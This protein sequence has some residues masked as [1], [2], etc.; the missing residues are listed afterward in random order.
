LIG[1]PAKSKNKLGWKPKYDL[2]ALV[3]E[4]ILSDLHLRKRDEYL[5]D[6]GFATLNYFE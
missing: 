6:G 3:K 1:D 5:K 4:M 2:P